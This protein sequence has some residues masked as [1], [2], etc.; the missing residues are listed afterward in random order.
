MARDGLFF[1]AIARIHPRTQA[2]VLAIMLQGAFAMVIAGISLFEA[3]ILLFQ[4]P[5]SGIAFAA[6]LLPLVMIL[7]LNSREVK[8]AFGMTEITE[9][10]A[11]M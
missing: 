10:P 9:P 2:P 1:P 7:Y 11:S 8:R 4:F 3:T 6:G 5:G